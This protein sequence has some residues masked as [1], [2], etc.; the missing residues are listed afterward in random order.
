[1]IRTLDLAVGGPGL[2][3]ITGTSVGSRHV[4]GGA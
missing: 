1:M 2:H 3:E 4:C